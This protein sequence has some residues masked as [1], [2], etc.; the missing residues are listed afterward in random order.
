MFSL[1]FILTI[2]S[3]G[4]TIISTSEI[5]D[6]EGCFRRIFQR[7]VR[8]V[9]AR[10]YLRFSYHCGERSE[11]RND[12]LP[13]YG[14]QSGGLVPQSGWNRGVLCFIPFVR[15]GA[16]LFFSV[17]LTKQNYNTL[18]RKNYGKSNTQRRCR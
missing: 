16:F 6:A 11:I 3:R 2:Y 15:D 5:V 18:R 8:T 1:N 4:N 7:A 13:R 17:P 12:V 10:Y 9:K 14:N